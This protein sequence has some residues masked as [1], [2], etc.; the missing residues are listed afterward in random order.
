M[1]ITYRIVAFD[2]MG[3]HAESDHATAEEAGEEVKRLLSQ[4]CAVSVAPHSEEES[5]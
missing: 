1:K 3:G 4:N 5:S 2:A